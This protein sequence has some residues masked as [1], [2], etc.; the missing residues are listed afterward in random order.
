MYNLKTSPDSRFCP[1]LPYDLIGTKMK[2]P[3]ELTLS[4]EAQRLLIDLNSGWTVTRS[5][6]RKDC[7][8]MPD[9]GKQ[10]RGSL[11]LTKGQAPDSALQELLDGGLI[12]VVG[13]TFPQPCGLTD[14][15]E[16]YYKRHLSH[17]C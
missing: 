9:Y 13:E 1:R 17:L 6:G 11:P 8:V 2:E 7:V 16:A 4:A 3:D 10:Q 12:E 5:S 14:M 15:G